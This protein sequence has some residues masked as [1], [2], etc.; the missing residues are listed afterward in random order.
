MLIFGA[1]GMTVSLAS[2]AFA[3]LE[4]A[5]DYLPGG[6]FGVALLSFVAL[7]LFICCYHVRRAPSC[8]RG[9]QPGAG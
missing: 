8:A 5:P 7:L 1:S 6:D 3:Q 9:R 4:L 2:L